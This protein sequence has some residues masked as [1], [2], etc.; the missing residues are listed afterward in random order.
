MRLLIIGTSHISPESVKKIQT[1]L[2][3]QDVA[4]V[5]IELDRQRLASLFSKD[6]KIDIRMIRK[7]GVGGFLFAIIGSYVQKKL[8]K[9][10]K[11]KPGDD[12]RA[13]IIAAKKQEIPIELIDQPIHI[14]LKRI[15]QEFTFKE[16]MRVVSDILKAMIF[17]KKELKKRGLD[18]F[19]LT[20]VPSNDVIHKL[21][22]ELRSRYPSLY[23][24]LVDERNHYMVKKLKELSPKYAG[25]VVVVIGAAHEKGMLEIL[26]QHI[27]RTT[28]PKEE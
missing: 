5:A 27:K 3:N 2:Q 25:L 4:A 17:G 10:I 12:M 19:D 14:T 22:E 15:S 23:K 6:T 28:T 20:K 9:Y 24:V 18:K 16:K 8:A 11:M 26:Q 21:V 13:A 1:T 7:V